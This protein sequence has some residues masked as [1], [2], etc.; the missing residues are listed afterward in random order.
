M[1]G[2]HLNG[3]FESVGGLLLL[4]NVR[5]AWRDQAIRG[6]HPLPS[7]FFWAWG[8]FNLWYYPSIGQRWSFWAGIAPCLANTAFLAV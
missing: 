5:R 7:V 2:D 3:I 6:L 4:M 1:T 8:A